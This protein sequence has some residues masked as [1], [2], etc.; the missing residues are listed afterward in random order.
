MWSI[1]AGPNFDWCKE[2]CDVGPHL[3]LVQKFS[4]TFSDPNYSFYPNKWSL[5]TTSEDLQSKEK[6]EKREW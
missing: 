1:G 4:V 6:G 2:L 5:P 3:W